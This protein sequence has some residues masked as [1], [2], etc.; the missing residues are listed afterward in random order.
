[1]SFLPGFY[2]FCLSCTLY[3]SLAV[4]SL[5]ISWAVEAI[6]KV[7][8]LLNA[9]VPLN[10]II[11]AHNHLAY[12]ED[13][14]VLNE[15]SQIMQQAVEVALGLPSGL[16]EVIPSEVYS[17]HYIPNTTHLK[18]RLE[19]V[20]EGLELLVNQQDE[21]IELPEEDSE[22]KKPQRAIKKRNATYPRV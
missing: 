17:K 22:V 19:G 13:W 9:F 16:I 20:F 1:M 3:C 5:R 11:L 6:S 14:H 7:R 8:I 15:A 21:T 10:I 18:N 4:I 2:P 12:S